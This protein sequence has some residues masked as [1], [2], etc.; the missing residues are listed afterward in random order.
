MT[1]E[2]MIFTEDPENDMWRELLRFS[3]SKNITKYMSEK[4]YSPTEDAINSIIGSF[5]QAHEYYK[6]ASEANLQISPLLLYYGTTNLLYGMTTLLNGNMIT[7]NNHGMRKI[8]PEEMHY[9]A[10]VKIHFE[11]PNDGGIHVYSRALG[12]NIDL[13]K[14]G[15]WRLKD[16]LDSIAEINELY[17]DCYGEACGKIIMLDVFNTPDG[18]VEKVYFN[19]TNKVIIE[20]LFQQI[21]GFSKSYL[22]PQTVTNNQTKETYFVLRHKINGT[23]INEVSYS[24]QPYLRAGHE[25]TC[26]SITI[27][28]ILYMYISLFVLA[29]LCRYN[30]ERWSPFVIQDSTGEKLLLEKLLY[31]SRRM[32]P[33][34]VLDHIY[35]KEYFFVSGKYASKNTDKLVS[36]HQVKDIVNSEFHKNIDAFRGRQKI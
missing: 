23:S 28:T 13:S 16:F 19:D 12:C 14:T 34:I 9:I 4:G 10:D 20:S 11:H 29:S 24:G 17:C 7:I 2:R 35:N 25:R 26:G 27:P 21:N 22:L 30:P 15:E 8:I 3:Y 36:E 18:K 6:Y 31:F 32:I 5:L 33:N 1:N